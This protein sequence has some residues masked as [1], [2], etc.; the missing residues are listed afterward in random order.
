LVLGLI[1]AV[2]DIGAG[3]YY[4]SKIN[5]EGFVVDHEPPEFDLQVVTA[6]ED[7]ITIR[8]D[9]GLDAATHSS[10]LGI[11]SATGYGRIGKVLS[12]SNGAVT[13]EYSV[14]EPSVTAGQRA[15]LDK[16]AFPGDPLRGRG[17]A[18]EDVEYESALG[19]MPAWYVRGTSDTWAIF[20]HGISGDRAEALRGLG[21][22]AET[23][24]H[25]MVIGYRNDTGL[26]G[27]PSGKYQYGL[28]EW[29]DVEGAVHYA[30]DSGAKSIV[31]VGYSMGGSIAMS[32]MRNSLERDRVAGLVLD[33]PMLDLAQTVNFAGARRR[34]P[35]FVTWT[36][37]VIAGL[38]YG[39]K[40]GELN[41]LKDADR[42]TVP[43]LL[44]HGDDDEKVPVSTSERLASAAPDRVRFERHPE[45]RHVGAWNAGP[46]RYEAALQEFVNSLGQ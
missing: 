6:G 32:F 8:P 19:P 7:R 17:L 24:A 28:T 46:E 38:R 16:Y 26:P 21:P 35:G 44:Y 34:I 30:A 27:D 13:R 23:G 14:L 10:V 5:G 33:S 43:I 12:E 41:Y 9:E 29:E 36:A 45:A 1:F 25:A 11:E 31:L 42:V 18:F 37:R 3:C 22:V 40:W 15:R 2:A 39:V 4:A 20:I